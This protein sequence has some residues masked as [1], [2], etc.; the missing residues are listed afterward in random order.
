MI[1][2]GVVGLGASGYLAFDARDTYNSALDTHCTG[3]K[4]MCSDEGLR[5]TADARG[6]ANLAT[7]FAIAGSVVAAGGLVL[8]LTAPSSGRAESLSRNAEAL[9][10]TPVIGAGAGLVVLGGRY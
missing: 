8:Y 1:G 2:V 10:V 4:D 5:L 3:A 7:V 6:Q 9:Y